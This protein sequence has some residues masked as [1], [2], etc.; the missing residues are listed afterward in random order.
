MYR[1][2]VTVKIGPVG[3]VFANGP[4][5]LGS[6]PGRVIQKK[7]LKWHLVPPCL[8]LSNIRYVSRIKWINPTKRVAPFPTPRCSSY[9]KE[10]ILVALN[11]GHQLYF[12]LLQ[13]TLEESRMTAMIF[14]LNDLVWF[15]GISTT[16]GYLMQNPLYEFILNIYKIYEHTFLI[17]LNEIKLIFFFIESKMV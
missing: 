7:L 11:Y 12:Y 9:W 10:S 6:I 4:G 2:K 5:N 1:D 17:I 8:T 16:I 15:Y 14:F 3:R 13:K